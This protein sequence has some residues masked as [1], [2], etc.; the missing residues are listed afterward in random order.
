MVWP[1]FAIFAFSFLLLESGLRTLLAIGYTSPSLMLILLVYIS[2]WAPTTIA[3]WA[4]L[5]LGLLVDLTTP[6]QV[7]HQAG[8]VSLIG[9]A[10]LGYV[11]GSYVTVQLRGMVFRDSALATAVLVFIAGAFVH[12]VVVAILTMRALPWPVAEPIPGWN[13]A[14]QLVARFLEL[15]YTGVITVPIAYVLTR[16]KWLWGFNPHAGPGASHHHGRRWSS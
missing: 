13:A 2:L 16:L 11:A 6:V 12:L 4:A 15:L 3:V 7:A 14:D 10:C 5:T 9:P 1:V 8:D